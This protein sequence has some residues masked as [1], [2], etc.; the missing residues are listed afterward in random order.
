[1]LRAYAI[2]GAVALAAGFALSTA[3][4]SAAG[5]GCARAATTAHRTTL[6]L[7]S[8]SVMCLVNTERAT[9]GLAPLGAS[10]LLS[11]AARRHSRDMVVRDYFSHVSPNGM[12]ARRRVLRTGYLRYRRGGSVGETIAWGPGRDSTPA[13]LV[14]SFMNSASHRLL[15]LDRR[16]R[17]VGVGMALGAPFAGMRGGATV[18]LD[19]GWRW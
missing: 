5:D 13:G 18:T 17:D 1:M 3:S 19:F 16:F 15:L 12:S 7:A 8:H 4:A 2:A 6:Q 14:S 9:R 10:R 11:R